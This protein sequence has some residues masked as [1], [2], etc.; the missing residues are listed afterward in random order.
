MKLRD[1]GAT[2][3][4][5]R[6]GFVAFASLLITAC[7]G[8]DSDD[9][10]APTS[11]PVAS[12]F[13]VS[14]ADAKAKCESLVGTV[15][16]P[17][18]VKTAVL[19]A[20]VTA[21]AARAQ[22]EHCKV[23]AYKTGKPIF[24]MEAL[25][26]S[27]WVG[28]LVH[29]GGGGLNGFLPSTFI[30]MWNERLPLQDGMVYIASNG[31]HNDFSGRLL[32]DR[33]TLRDY[34]YQHIGTTYDFGQAIMANYYANKPKNNYFM[35]CSRGGG[36]AMA[37]AA[38]YPDN[39]D[40]IVAQAP[41]PEMKAFIARAASQGPLATVA[42]TEWNSI[43]SAYIEQC[44]ALDGVKD[45]VV[46]A[47]KA[48]TFDPIQWVAAQN[49]TPAKQDAVKSQYSDLKLADGTVVNQKYPLG[50][51]FPLTDYLGEPW[52]RIARSDWSWTYSVKNF[53]LNS[54]WRNISS[55]AD[56]VS[57][58]VDPLK[59]AQFL[60]KGKKML[61]YMGLDDAA[62][63]IEA[64]DAYINNVK[65][66]AGSSSINTQTRYFPGVGHCGAT[67]E[68]TQL[69]PNSA[70]MLGALRNWV[71]TDTAPGNMVATRF[72]ADGT[73]KA[74]RPLC[75]VG[76]HPQ[77]KGTGDVNLAESYSCVADGA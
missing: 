1:F 46:S 9:A 17:A 50:E 64:T 44:D 20:A 5:H 77:Y 30:P 15:I 27:T 51:F 47:K 13:P 25:L 75:L 61:V 73:V 67:N 10:A 6:L 34:S 63:S 49:W 58:D 33:E 36:E 45:G 11:P 32:L 60:K 42:T 65:T 41:A 57:L 21:P 2:H 43:L 59:L 71:E 29:G 56:S 53:D 39:Y 4:H 70:D 76:T 54:D 74:R 3:V 40:G 7:G 38:L 19:E 31:G 66:A 35:G 26:P 8:G 62:L 72:N 55:M 37:A 68:T 23:V 18:T 24:E 48:C 16:G 69:G 22:G 14:I 28:A 12:T 52:L